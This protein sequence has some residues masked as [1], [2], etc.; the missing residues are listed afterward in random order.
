[1]PWGMPM[2]YI[3]L[4]SFKPLMIGSDVMPAAREAL[5]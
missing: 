1:M 3:V 4:N 5:G 2:S